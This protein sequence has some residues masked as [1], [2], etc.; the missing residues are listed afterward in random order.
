MCYNFENTNQQQLMKESSSSWSTDL[1][2]ICVSDV[3]PNL[4]NVSVC[5]HF[6][7]EIY[8]SF[9]RVGTGDKIWRCSCLSSYVCGLACSYSYTTAWCHEKKSQPSQAWAQL[10]FLWAWTTVLTTDSITYCFSC[11]VPVQ[12][13]LVSGFRDIAALTGMLIFVQLFVGIYL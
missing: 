12:F 4:S 3:Y 5:K 11:S 8:I 10:T 9:K 2:I 1:W 6:L 7:M 13:K